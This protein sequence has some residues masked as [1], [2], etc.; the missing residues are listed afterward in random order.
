MVLEVI[1]EN[2]E[3]LKTKPSKKEE[4]FTGDDVIDAYFNG[5]QD[6]L[7]QTDKV[8]F[9]GFIKNLERAMNVAAQHTNVLTHAGFGYR[10]LLLKVKGLTRFNAMF[11]V[12]EDEWRKPEFN[13]V[14][15]QSLDAED[16]V[17]E[18]L[19]EFSIIFMPTSGNRIDLDA[20]RSD[21]Y[22]LSYEPKEI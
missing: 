18:E 11:I 16:M 10:K 21:G 8:L 13:L 9:Q 3:L 15:D 7:A 4:V 22:H 5:K 1:H 20:L 17:S 12:E 14:Y 19:F 6:G 2:W